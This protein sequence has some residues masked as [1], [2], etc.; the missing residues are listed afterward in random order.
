MHIWGLA[1]QASDQ[2][3]LHAGFLAFSLLMR[4]A[5]CQQWPALAPDCNMAAAA[6]AWLLGPQHMYPYSSCR[7]ADPPCEFFEPEVGPS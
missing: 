5:N 4:P 6:D 3:C 7:R 2:E 1:D